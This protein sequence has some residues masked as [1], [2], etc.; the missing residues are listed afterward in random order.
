MGLGWRTSGLLYCFVVYLLDYSP[1][2]FHFMG[3]ECKG[4]QG[5]SHILY[6]I[7]HSL[8]RIRLNSCNE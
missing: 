4:K 6:I 2:F 3:T 8:N 1:W 7:T 5:Y